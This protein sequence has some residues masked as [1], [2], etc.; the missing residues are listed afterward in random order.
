M[1][2]Q[3]LLHNSDKYVEAIEEWEGTGPALFLAGGV[4]A[5]PD[6]QQEIAA[7][8]QESAWTILNPRR[9]HFP[10]NDLAAAEEQIE[11]EHRHL[12]RATVILFWLPA[13]SLCPISLYELG[14]WSMTDKPLFVG[15][16]PD[17]PRRL[18]IETQTRLARPDVS[19]VYS[20]EDLARQA[21]GG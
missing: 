13:E 2:S 6:W 12:R 5:C 20:L 19:V 4:T 7:L 16:H 14:A 21:G 1:P 9:A 18:D 10:M 15:V 11:W 17:Y 8:L 3:R